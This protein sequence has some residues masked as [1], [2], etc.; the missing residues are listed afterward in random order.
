MIVGNFSGH[1]SY[2]LQLEPALPLF[3]TSLGLNQQRLTVE[4][5]S[6][7]SEQHGYKPL[8]QDIHG[9]STNRQPY[10]QTMPQIWSHQPVRDSRALAA[11]QLEQHDSTQP[12]LEST[13]K[14]STLP[15]NAHNFGNHARPLRPSP[16]VSS[17]PQTQTSSMAASIAAVRAFSKFELITKP[18]SNA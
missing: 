2:R 3:H 11:A 16:D 10:R 17:P 8:Q 18:C 4:Q 15:S 6:H 12:D 13:Y 14:A 1:Q 5:S 9:L 7:V